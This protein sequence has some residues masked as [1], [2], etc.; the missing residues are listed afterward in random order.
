MTEFPQSYDEY[1]ARLDEI[2]KAIVDWNDPDHTFRGY[3]EVSSLLL[4]N[5][6]NNNKNNSNNI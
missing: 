5:K 6:N 4:K 2:G 1:M 3:T